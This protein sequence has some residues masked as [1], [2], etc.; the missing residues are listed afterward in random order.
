MRRLQKENHLKKANEPEELVVLTHGKNTSFPAWKK[1]MRTEIGQQY[2]L[3]TSILDSG[4]LQDPAEIDIESYGDL[5]AEGDLHRIN[6]MRL[7]AAVNNRE[8]TIAILNANAPKA[9]ALMWKY[10]SMNSQEAVQRHEQF[11][12]V[13]DLNDPLALYLS[14]RATHTAGGQMRMKMIRSPTQDRPIRPYAKG[15]RRASWSTR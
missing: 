14:I 6:V 2:G 3:L 12:E 5:T 7:R 15:Q 1:A 9:Y 13:A 10:L 4:E 8:K 11:D